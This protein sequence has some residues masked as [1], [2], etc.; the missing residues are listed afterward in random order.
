MS[1]AAAVTVAEFDNVV[2]R[3]EIPVLVDFWAVWC[4]PCRA[5]APAVDAIAIE[6]AGKAKVVKV[7]VDEEQEIAGRYGVS[8]IPTLAIFKPGKLVD[9]IMGAQPKSAISAKLGEYTK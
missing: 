1:S 3:S 8:S 6:F 2:L 9:Q 4:G 5:V 7:N